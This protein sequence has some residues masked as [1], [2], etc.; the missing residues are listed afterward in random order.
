MSNFNGQFHFNITRTII[1][2][3]HFSLGN[4]PAKIMHQLLNQFTKVHHLS[5][6]D[7]KRVV[8]DKT[9]QIQS[10]KTQDEDEM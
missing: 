10:I 1:A 7:L 5:A 4:A 6:S 3:F 9:L 8:L 2:F